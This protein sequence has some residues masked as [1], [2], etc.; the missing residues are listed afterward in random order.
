MKASLPPRAITASSTVLISL[1]TSLAE[2]RERLLREQANDDDFAI[3]VV[4]VD[5]HLRPIVRE[6][7][8]RQLR[9]TEG[10]R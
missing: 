1:E 5:A 6:L 2:E 10:S 9:E 8:S 4:R 3:M 7:A